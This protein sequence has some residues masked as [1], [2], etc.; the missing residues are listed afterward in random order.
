MDVLTPRRPIL[1]MALGFVALSLVYFAKPL[2][3][4]QD[5]LQGDMGSFFYPQRLFFAQSI[6]QG[7]FPYWNP[8]LFCGSPFV[9]EPQ[10]AV[11]YPLTWMFVLFPGPATIW[12]TLIA[13][14]TLA[15]LGTAL[16]ARETVAAG[17]WAS[18]CGGI[19]YAF[20]GFFCMHMGHLNQVMT[21]TWSPWVLWAAARWLKQPTR[22]RFISLALFYGLQFLP[23]GA[24]NN[25]YLSLALVALALGH[26]S[27]RFFQPV[28]GGAGDGMASGRWKK[29]VGPGLGMMAAMALGIGLS[30]VQLLPTFELIRYSV[31]WGGL[32]FDYAG[33]NSLPPW[34]PLADILFPN[35]SGY[36]GA[37]GH[38][39]G[40]IAPSELAGYM[41][42]VAVALAAVAVV[43]EWN[44]SAVRLWAALALAA[45]VLAW[46]RYTPV[47]DVFYPL[48]LRFFRNPSRF[49]YLVTLAVAVLSAAGAQRVLD[50]Q[51]PPLQARIHRAGAMLLAAAGILVLGF[52]GGYGPGSLTEKNTF[53]ALMAA[54]AGFGLLAAAAAY[55]GI[56]ANSLTAK[57]VLLAISFALPLFA[58]VRESE[59]ANLSSRSA[60]SIQKETELADKLRPNLGQ[61]RIFSYHCYD[62]RVNRNMVYRLPDV[63]GM[64]GGL[65]P[66][67]RYWELHQRMTPDSHLARTKGRQLL[68]LLGGRW[69]LWDRPPEEGKMELAAEAGPYRAYLNEH[70]RPRLS[71]ATRGVALSDEET[72][73]R[74]ATGEW[75]MKEEVFL[76]SAAGLASP[77]VV[78]HGVAEPGKTAQL[79]ITEESNNRV[80][81]E[82]FAPTS[83]YLVLSD[84]YY[85][86]WRVLVDGI[87]AELRRA[88][89]LF[90]AVFLTPARHR[91][92]FV[93]SPHIFLAGA[94]LTAISGLI[95]VLLLIPK[96]RGK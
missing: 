42:L 19:V 9:A 76:D 13:H 58:F 87:P 85:P 15:G 82:V 84:S 24:E 29:G 47:Y 8:H 21:C 34:K 86:G 64:D 27:V 56:V 49:I 88:N 40:D 81:C 73:A 66:L 30:G 10:N 20:S 4:G 77:G 53:S 28:S 33:K 2:L 80:E 89:Y 63:S 44:R 94:A 83:G 36:Y 3:L 60:A 68:D 67:G 79:E 16:L 5:F 32:A 25:F 90:R 55:R 71:F 43:K 51:G 61:H 23:G 14:L 78:G 26:T 18:F 17:L 72:V 35:Y 59:F 37:A 48:G 52:L 6:R 57:Q 54:D 11:F 22:G 62:L 91:V 75:D 31:R 96:T 74:M 46:G 1:L 39:M 12:A 50:A 93:Y 45:L 41:G 7:D 92:L 69:V 65:L 95:L 38:R 70:A